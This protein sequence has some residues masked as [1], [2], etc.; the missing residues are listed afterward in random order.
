MFEK[1]LSKSGL[2]LDRLRT[3]CQIAEAGGI[4]RGMVYRRAGAMVSP[5]ALFDARLG[6]L[7]GFERPPGF[8]F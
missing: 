4:S 5:S 6:V 3:F 2:S 8:Q 1:L 7:P